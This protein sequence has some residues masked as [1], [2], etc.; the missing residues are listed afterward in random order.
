MTDKTLKREGIKQI[1]KDK[2]NEELRYSIRSIFQYIPWIHKIY[3]IMP[4]LKVKFFKP[5]EKIKEKILYINDKEFLGFDS[6]N[7]YSFTF[8][9]FQLKRFGVS[10]NFIY[11]EDDFFI[12]KHLKKEDFFYYDKKKKKVLP[13]ILTKFFFEMNKTEVLK[14]IIIIFK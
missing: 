6:A 12:G 4:N 2:D 9:L 1:Y 8:N 13:F 11:M 7:I 10:R 14:N 5:I 3:I